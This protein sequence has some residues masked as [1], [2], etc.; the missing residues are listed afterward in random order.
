MA[1]IKRLTGIFKP[2]TQNF[3]DGALPQNWKDFKIETPNSEAN[4]IVKASTT[5]Q[6]EEWLKH[7]GKKASVDAKVTAPHLNAQGDVSTLEFD[8]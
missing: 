7:A 2:V 5:L 6:R 1:E 3:K 4:A 8:D